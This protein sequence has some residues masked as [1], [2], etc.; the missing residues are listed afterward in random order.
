MQHDRSALASRVGKLRNGAAFSDSR[1]ALKHRDRAVAVAGFFEL[2]GQARQLLGSA[3]KGSAVEQRAGIVALIDHFADR[4]RRRNA[5]ELEV[6]DIAE[7]KCLT[8]RKHINYE[9][10]A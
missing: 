8:C 1:L 3:Y 10:T 5:F 4:G 6:T 2:D 9:P 7:G